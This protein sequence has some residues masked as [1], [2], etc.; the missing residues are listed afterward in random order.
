MDSAEG[1]VW[2]WEGGSTRCSAQS[3]AV[4]PLGLQ[5]ISGDRASIMD[6]K[7]ICAALEMDRATKLLSRFVGPCNRL[8]KVIARPACIVVNT[9]PSHKP[10]THWLAIFFGNNGI[11]E[12]FN[13]F[14]NQ[15]ARTFEN[16]LTKHS[17]TSYYNPV[18]LQHPLTSICGQYCI[19]YLV[20]RARGVPVDEIVSTF[21]PTDRAANDERLLDW[22][23]D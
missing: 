12:F 9:D 13:S 4:Y 23:N 10:G 7:Q 6:M 14:G 20:K 8:P 2:F 3:S 18:P 5:T 17:R 19:Y 22:F 1:V 21:D 15:P 11:G 16:Y